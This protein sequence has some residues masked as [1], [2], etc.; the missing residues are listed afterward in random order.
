MFLFLTAT[1]TK[2][3]VLAEQVKY[4]IILELFL[5]SDRKNSKNEKYTPKGRPFESTEEIANVL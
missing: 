3:T 4:K 5:V 2:A 1:T